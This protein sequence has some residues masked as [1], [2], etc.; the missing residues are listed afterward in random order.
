MPE[1]E[2]PSSGLDCFGG[3]GFQVDGANVSAGPLAA[4]S[5]TLSGT[6]ESGEAFSVSFQQGAEFGTYTGTIEVP[7]PGATLLA[8]IALG[9]TGLLRASAIRRRRIRG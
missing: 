3:T 2:L 8:G 7:E 9:M 6:L 1:P 5:G 4:T